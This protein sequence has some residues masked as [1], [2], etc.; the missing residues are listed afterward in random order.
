MLCKISERKENI[1]SK[2]EKLFK[3][4]AEKDTSKYFKKGGLGELDFLLRGLSLEWMESGQRGRGGGK[5][6]RKWVDVLCT[7]VNQQM[8]WPSQDV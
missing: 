5:K 2:Y 8:S 4:I 7:P 6:G 1:L 3:D